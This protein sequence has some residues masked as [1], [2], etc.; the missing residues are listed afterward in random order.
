MTTLTNAP[1]FQASS[2]KPA[3]G[4]ESPTNAHLAIECEI[5]ELLAVSAPQRLAT[6]GDGNLIRR[7][8]GE[9]WQKRGSRDVGTSS[10]PLI[11]S[12]PAIWVGCSTKRNEKTP[13]IHSP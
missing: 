11:M 12:V 1:R 7:P 2:L 13:A 5:E 4:E 8:S 3:R 10:D 6:A 9:K